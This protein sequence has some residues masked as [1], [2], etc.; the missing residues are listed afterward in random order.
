DAL[1]GLRAHP[2][3]FAGVAADDAGQLAGV[4]VG[5]GG[6]QVDL[7][8]HRDDLQVG[9]ERQ[10]QVGQRLRLDALGGVDEQHG[11]LAGGQAAGDL[12]AEVDVAG[13]VDEVEHVLLVFAGPGKPDRL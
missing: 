10:V 9:V 8:E 6:G 2:E 7:V 1:A 3:D 5:L 11:A 13:G 4:P 12:V